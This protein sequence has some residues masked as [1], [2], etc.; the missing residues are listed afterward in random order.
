MLCLAQKSQA[1]HRAS[2]GYQLLQYS[3]L[4]AE[5]DQQH[6]KDQGVDADQ[7]GQCQQTHSR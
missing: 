4:E 5:E 2:H 6:P 3:P 1:E 7:P